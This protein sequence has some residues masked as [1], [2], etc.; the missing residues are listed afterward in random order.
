MRKHGRVILL[1]YSDTNSQT[2]SRN[3]GRSEYSYYFVLRCFRPLLAQI[4]I[5]IEVTDPRRQVDEIWCNARCHGEDCKFLSFSPPHKTLL[6]LRCPTIPVFAWEFDTIPYDT[7]DGEARHDWT[8]VLRSLGHA[9]VHSS[10]TVATIRRAVGRSVEVDSIPAPVWDRYAAF[11]DVSTAPALSGP[12]S[13]LTL[14]VPCLDSRTFR[15]DG[16]D[17]CHPE[18][19]RFARAAA[20]FDAQT[21]P[22]ILQLDGVIYTSVLNPFDS[23]KRLWDMLAHFVW[24]LRDRRDATLLLKTTHSD[25]LL[26]MVALL[27]D[28]VRLMPFQCRIIVIH[29]LL[30]QATYDAIVR[31]TTYVV[32]CSAGEGQCLPLMEFLSC[33]K[34]AIAPRNSA[35]AD[36]ITET[37]SFVVASHPEPT[38]WPQ[39]TRE[40][41]RTLRARIDFHSLMLAFQESFVVARCDARRY[42][43]MSAN[44]SESLRQ[45]CSDAVTLDRLRSAL[46]GPVE[47]EKTGLTQADE[48]R[49]TDALV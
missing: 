48:N 36:Y 20:I 17:L 7:W 35:M 4:G 33:G 19:E 43:A 45:H 25:M 6:G 23:R 12:R 49:L 34:P 9:I 3:I 41:L 2:I 30:P 16:F 11:R 29:G 15:L 38:S 1:V 18:A 8:S 42:E 22:Q 21:N 46:L 24:A 28:F 27:G 39:D 40:M 44:A 47:R 14:R 5:V 32:N 26:V 31:S 10:D 13:A 37:N